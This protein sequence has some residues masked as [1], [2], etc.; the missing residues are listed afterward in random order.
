ME[1]ASV[2]MEFEAEILDNF[3]GPSWL[4]SCRRQ[5]VLLL[6][7][8]PVPTEEKEDWRYSD[9]ANF[10]PGCFDPTRYLPAAGSGQSNDIEALLPDPIV[11]DCTAGPF[12]AAK[13]AGYEKYG[14]KVIN[15]AEYVAGNDLLIQDL[16]PGESDRV[17]DFILDFL[18]PKDGDSFFELLAKSFIDLPLVVYIPESYRS[19]S[20]IVVNHRIQA[21]GFR[22]SANK[23]EAEPTDSLAKRPA[24]FPSLMIYAAPGAEAK[25]L[26]VLSSDDSPLLAVSRTSLY[27]G[28]KAKLGY[29]Q[30]QIFGDKTLHYGHS[31]SRVLG[32][33]TLTSFL[34]SIGADMSRTETSSTLAE[35]GAVSRLYAM[36]FASGS[37]IKDMR[38]YQ[39][40]VAAR[41]KS[42]LIFKGAIDDEARSVYTGLITMRK[43]A[44]RAE[45]AQTNRNLVLSEGARA[46]SVPNL[47]IE[48]NDV[49]CSHASAV[50]PIDEELRFYLESRGLEKELASKLI[51]LGVFKDLLESSPIGEINGYIYNKIAQHL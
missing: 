33:G 8:T 10:D 24:Y 50:G 20:V 28:A 38:T 37:Q 13:A 45:A 12:S 11:I 49:K 48:E 5:A 42:E 44:L 46:D 26:E 31:Y 51:A 6:A 19:E 39:D 3:S 29:E 30:L 16:P 34:A 2:N 21:A 36:Y 4:Q 23:S 43:G 14:I 35:Q 47:S 32:D 25:V 41:T 1:V 27:I 17:K 18:Q 7:K 9:I 15:L 22:T 40:H